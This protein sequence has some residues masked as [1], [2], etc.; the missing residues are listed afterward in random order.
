MGRGKKIKLQKIAFWGVKR[1]K[2]ES[3][4]SKK[5]KNGKNHILAKF[6]I[7][8]PFLVILMLSEDP[9]P[10]TRKTP[11]GKMVLLRQKVT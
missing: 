8:E 7:L 9:R 2:N 6:F 5:R 3:K 11:L 1:A 4:W 10:Y